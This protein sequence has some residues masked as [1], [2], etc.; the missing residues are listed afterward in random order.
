MQIK[1]LLFVILF[2]TCCS[3]DDGWI[4]LFNGENLEGWRASEHKETFQVVDGAIVA[5]GD[6]SHLFYAGEVGGADFKDFEWRCEVLLEPGSNSGMFFHT[7]YQEVGW[8]EK[9]YEAQLNNTQRDRKKTGGLYDIAD[10]MDNSPAKDNEWFTQQVTV[11]GNRVTVTVNGEI[12][13][14]YTEPEG[15]AD[16]P[17]RRKGRILSRG[18]IALQGHDPDS[19]A[20]FR[21]VEIRLLD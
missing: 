12:V 20:R 9:G 18:T 1:S 3:A 19:I 6:R 17:D 15:A 10:V 7:E 11:R 13:T 16:D 2:A 21:K 14:D 5:H 4:S 8:P